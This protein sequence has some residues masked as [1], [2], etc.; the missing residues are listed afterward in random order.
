MLSDA[1]L[2]EPLRLALRPSRFVLSLGLYRKVRKGFRKERKVQ[3]VPV[4]SGCER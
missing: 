3:T 4:P 1:F 2:R